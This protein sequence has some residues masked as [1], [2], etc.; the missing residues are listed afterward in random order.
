MGNCKRHQF[1]KCKLGYCLFQQE[2]FQYSASCYRADM[3]FNDNRIR[4][5]IYTTRIPY[6]IW[7]AGIRNPSF[8]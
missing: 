4:P 3:D 7:Y 1:I 8:S 6:G 2:I 5:W